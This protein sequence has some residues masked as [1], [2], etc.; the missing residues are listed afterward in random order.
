MRSASLA[1]VCNVHMEQLSQ[2]RPCGYFGQKRKG[3]PSEGLWCNSR[4]HYS[5]T[6]SP[7]QAQSHEKNEEGNV[8]VYVTVWGYKQEMK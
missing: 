6:W 2:E 1:E 3:F 7:S 4:F 5:V 8:A